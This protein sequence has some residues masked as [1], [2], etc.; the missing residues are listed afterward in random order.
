MSYYSEPDS[1]ITTTV[2]NTKISDIDNKTPDTNSLV[3][4]TVLHPKMNEIE[5]KIPNHNKYIT[6]PKFN[7]LTP[8][9]FSV[10]L[11]QANFQRETGFDNKL[12]SFYR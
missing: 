2:L 4:T 3:T 12:I 9:R 7:K 5:N 11:K 1:H 10:R 8:E 6:T